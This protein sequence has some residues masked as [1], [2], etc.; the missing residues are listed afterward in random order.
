MCVDC[1]LVGV[2]KG[3]GR[4]RRG[5]DGSEDNQMC[6]ISDVG[7][8]SFKECMCFFFFLVADRD[9]IGSSLR[10]LFTSR[11]RVSAVRWTLSLASLSQRHTSGEV[12]KGKQDNKRREVFFSLKMGHRE[13]AFFFVVFLLRM[14]SLSSLK[15]SF[16]S[17]LKKL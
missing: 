12:E 1:V 13:L 14:T 2:Q 15:K 16:F 11:K 4:G 5:R 7:F 10:R 17:L 8:P 9:L 6:Y 3:E